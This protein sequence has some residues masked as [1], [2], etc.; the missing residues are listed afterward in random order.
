M[1][2]G[3]SGLLT[4]DGLRA[5][6]RAAMQMQ[7]A[8]GRID[9]ARLLE[10]ADAALRDHLARV[11]ISGAYAAAAVS[12]PTRALDDCLRVLRRKRLERERHEIQ[13]AMARARS[14]GDSDSE[15]TLA[16]RMIDV[17]REIHETR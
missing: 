1:E 2:V 15:R 3:L 7:Q 11:V 9:P 13:T 12:D 16:G 6:Y 10:A 14:E 4:N 5:T 8:T 17:E